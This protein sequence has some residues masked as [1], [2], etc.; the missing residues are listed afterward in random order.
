MLKGTASND[1]HILKKGVKRLDS[2]NDLYF[3]L[4]TENE[5]MTQTE[6]N[7]IKQVDVSTLTSNKH[8]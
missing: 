8:I 4:N 6:I 5:K 2:L 3:N 7:L 1:R